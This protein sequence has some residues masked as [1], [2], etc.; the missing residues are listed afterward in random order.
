MLQ[1]FKFK[2]LKHR[3]KFL[4]VKHKATMTSESTFGQFKKLNPSAFKGEFDPIVVESWTLDLEKYFNILNFS[5]T[6]KVVFATFMLSVEAE[7]WWRMEKRLLGNEE[8]LVWDNFKEV[9]FKK[10]FPRSVRRQKESE[11]IQLKQ[12]N[13]TVTDYGTKFA[14]L[15]HFS[16]DLIST[17]ER[18]AFNFQ[19]GLS[20][21]FKDKL[22]RWR[23]F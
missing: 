3:L 20:P 1:K 23:N 6:Q 2:L 16:S 18:K 10:Y 12:S 13:M 9:F 22:V 14:S 8:P 17:E 11:F 5:K 15:F 21:F 19:E 7:H 4:T